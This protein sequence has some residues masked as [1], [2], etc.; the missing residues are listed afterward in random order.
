MTSKNYDIINPSKVEKAPRHSDL[1]NGQ[2]INLNKVNNVSGFV[3]KSNVNNPHVNEL[4]QRA[5]QNDANVF[6]RKG[7]RGIIE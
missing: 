2:I 4:F 7:D 3:D 5:Y 1:Y 6:R